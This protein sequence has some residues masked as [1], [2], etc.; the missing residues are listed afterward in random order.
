MFS[1]SHHIWWMCIA[2]TI[3]TWFH[4]QYSV[5]YDLGPLSMIS[6]VAISR[7]LKS[8][9]KHLFVITIAL[10]IR[11]RLSSWGSG[12][13]MNFTIHKSVYVD[14][15]HKY[16]ERERTLWMQAYMRKTTT[17]QHINK[18]DIYI[19]MYLRKYIVHIMLLII[20]SWHLFH[21]QFLNTPQHNM[22]LTKVLR[23][24]LFLRSQGSHN[25]VLRNSKE[26]LI[27]CSSAMMAISGCWRLG[28]KK[29]IQLKFYLSWSILFSTNW[30]E[31]LCV[32]S[33]WY[34]YASKTTEKMFDF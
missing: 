16:S 23:W 29:H 17:I 11:S 13:L 15:K 28:T 33:S 24:Q 9:K 19:Y 18:Y 26:L 4:W 5:H 20:F 27:C 1:S 32:S 34:V 21:H 31:G 25:H 8:F 30:N 2:R 12:D 10:W 3:D 7:L 22:K 6:S 14:I